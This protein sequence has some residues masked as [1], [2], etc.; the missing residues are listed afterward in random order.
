MS[1]VKVSSVSEPKIVLEQFVNVNNVNAVLSKAKYKLLYVFV[2]LK[3]YT[4]DN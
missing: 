4:R 1:Q 3:R 2:V